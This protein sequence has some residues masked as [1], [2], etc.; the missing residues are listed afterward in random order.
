MKA[1]VFKNFDAWAKQKQIAIYFIN[2]LH[3]V[4]QADHPCHNYESAISLA[5]M[6][7][8][9]DNEH[10]VQSIHIYSNFV[11]LKRNEKGSFAFAAITFDHVSRTLSPEEG[12]DFDPKTNLTEI[13]RAEP[14]V[15]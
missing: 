7:S 12:K 8:R 15:K 14:P 6:V 10:L 11:R 4:D 13:Y 2:R 5:N 1:D 3:S 9:L